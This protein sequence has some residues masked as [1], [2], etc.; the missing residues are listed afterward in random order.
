MYYWDVS[1]EY[2]LDFDHSHEDRHLF[3]PRP[4]S[5]RDSQG[6]IRLDI[7]SAKAY[8]FFFRATDGW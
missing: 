4:Q 6:I 8:H 7:V 2:E 3:A 5:F 1:P